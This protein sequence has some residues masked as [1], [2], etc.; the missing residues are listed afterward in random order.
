MFSKNREPMAAA[1]RAPVIRFAAGS[2]GHIPVSLSSTRL[3]LPFPAPRRVQ[4][5]MA[6]MAWIFA[7]RLHAGWKPTLL[8]PIHG[9]DEI[10]GSN[11]AEI[12]PDVPLKGLTLPA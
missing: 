2:G 1:S 3:R 11:A 9:I 8:S 12:Q 4:P 6:W 10:H 5:W 7:D